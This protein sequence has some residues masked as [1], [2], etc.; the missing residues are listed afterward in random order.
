MKTKKLILIVIFV[1]ITT[2]CC[3][4]S[5][6]AYVH[7][8]KGLS[9]VPCTIYLDSAFTSPAQARCKDAM[10]TWNDGCF[11]YDCLVYGGTKEI[12]SCAIIDDCNTI[13]FVSNGVTYL[14][15][16]SITQ[17]KYT[18]L[19]LDWYVVEFDININPYYTWYTNISETAITL[20][21]YED[22]VDMQSV[23]LHE[24]GHALG[25]SH[26]DSEYYNGQ[27]TVMYA[28]MDPQTIVR[29]LSEDD[30]LGVVALY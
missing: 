26:T 16:T 25:L 4:L 29:A 10:A 12:N 9:S 11:S 15:E 2:L 19:W 8:H 22:Y 27:H 17:K 18:F 6:S 28:Y 21:A 7:W 24:L 23:V 5:A 14:G 20:A 3:V 30:R 13:S 1:F